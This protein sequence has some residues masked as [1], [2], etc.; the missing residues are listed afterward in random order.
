MGNC[1]SGGHDKESDVDIYINKNHKVKKITTE[2]DQ[3]EI[4]QQQWN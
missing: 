4:S 1:S 2:K 3:F